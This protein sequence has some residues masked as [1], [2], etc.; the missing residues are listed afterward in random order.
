[1]VPPDSG[2][3]LTRPVTFSVFS[4]TSAATEVVAKKRLETSRLDKKVFRISIQAVL[5]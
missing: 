2:S 5:I 1:M 4:A 3:T